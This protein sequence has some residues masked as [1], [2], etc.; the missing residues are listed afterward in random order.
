MCTA[1]IINVLI[2]RDG[3]SIEKNQLII[4]GVTIA[5]LAIFYLFPLIRN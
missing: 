4:A 5:E 1:K 3:H 2:C